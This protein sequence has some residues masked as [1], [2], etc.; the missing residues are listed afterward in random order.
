MVLNKYVKYERNWIKGFDLWMKMPTCPKS[1]TQ[2]PKSFVFMMKKSSVTWWYD[3]P[4]QVYE[5]WSEL[6][7]GYWSYKW[8]FQLALKL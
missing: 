7:K 6:D 2:L 8:K 3:G 4:E 5:V 1:L